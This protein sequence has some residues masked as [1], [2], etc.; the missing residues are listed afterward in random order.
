MDMESNYGLMELNMKDNG[1]RIKLR[2][3]VHFG[4]LR[5]MYTKVN[6]MMTKLTAMVSILTSMEANMKDTGRMICKKVMGVKY[7]VMELNIQVTIK[8]EK[9]IIMESMSG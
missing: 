6:F 8:K 5:E 4:M 2:V 1:M 7:G 9:S 3:K